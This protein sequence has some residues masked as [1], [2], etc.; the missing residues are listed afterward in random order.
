[1]PLT[2]DYIS[3]HEIVASYMATK[4]LR[5]IFSEKFPSAVNVDYAEKCNDDVKPVAVLRA[6]SPTKHNEV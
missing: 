1:M 5:F 6:I 4:N 2:T 3:V